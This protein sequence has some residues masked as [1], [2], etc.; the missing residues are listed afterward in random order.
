MYCPQSMRNAVTRAAA[1]ATVFAQFRFTNRGA[2]C[3]T[4][5]YNNFS[6]LSRKNHRPDC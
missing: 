2:F 1:P 3:Y 6:S 5:Y 4:Y